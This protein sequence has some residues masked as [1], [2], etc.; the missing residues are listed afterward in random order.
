MDY[1]TY[2]EHV[3]DICQ[4]VDISRQEN[5]ITHDRVS[6]VHEQ[7]ES[8]S[9]NIHEASEDH[10]NQDEESHE[11]GDY[12]TDTDYE[13]N[14]TT[15]KKFVPYKPKSK[16]A[17]ITLLP[18]NMYS[19]LSAEDKQVWGKL[20]PEGR[21][22]IIKRINEVAK[23]SETPEKRVSSHHE[24]VEIQVHEG[25]PSDNE[26]K[27]E[28]YISEREFSPGQLELQRRVALAKSMSCSNAT[29]DAVAVVLIVTL[30][31]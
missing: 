10:D 15:Q 7:E 21:A 4:S 19:T 13:V 25:I 24:R 12:V 14:K 8:R 20:S 6:E 26:T 31:M 18:S 5:K 17:M 30:R 1:Q 29:F 2:H 22:I 16:A 23:P 9:I 3:E 27:Q 28:S 11:D